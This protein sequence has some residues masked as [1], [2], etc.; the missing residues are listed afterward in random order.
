MKHV[1]AFAD[2]FFFHRGL[3]HGMINW[4]YLLPRPPRNIGIHRNIWLTAKPRNMPLVLFFFIE[5][6][7]WLRWVLFSGWRRCFIVV[8]F[9]GHEI[10]KKEG[11]TITELLPR[12]IILS[13]CHCV[14]PLEIVAFKLYGNPPDRS[15][16]DYVFTHELP[17]YHIWR[18]RHLDGN[19][20]LSSLLQDKYLSNKK[21]G[22][23]GVPTVP[24][25]AVLPRGSLF[26]PG[27]FLKKHPHLFCKPRHGSSSRDS[28]VISAHDQGGHY[29]IFSTRNG[30]KKQISSLENIQDA[31]SRDD[32]LV[33]PFMVNHHALTELCGATEAVTVRVITEKHPRYGIRCYCATLEIPIH[34]D[35]AVFFHIMLPID[36]DSGRVMPFP[37]GHLPNTA[38]TRY[39]TLLAHMGEFIVPH[40]PSLADSAL[41]SHI[42]FPDI[43]AIGWDYVITSSGP[44]LLE[45]NTG[46]GTKTPQV[47]LGGLIGE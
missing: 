4:R 17:A 35:K 29:T 5:G 6:A 13:L 9:R 20:E 16:W 1:F 44:Y 11:I 41:K 10:A 8:K 36:P 37:H 34:E 30:L 39:D 45:G 32:F 19:T 47:I 40:W 46:W 15:I 14:P 25:L 21:L 23:T 12:L 43:Y 38:Q 42:I 26:D 2:R 33:Q 24:V 31:L 27:S 28:F 22:E 3:P 7:L 18:S